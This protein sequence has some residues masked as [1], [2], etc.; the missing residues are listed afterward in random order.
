MS[1]IGICDL[2]ALKPFSYLE[3]KTYLPILYMGVTHQKS[4]F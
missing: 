1:Q 4:T 2:A 3:V